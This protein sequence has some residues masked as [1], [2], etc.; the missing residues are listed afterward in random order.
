MPHQPRATPPNDRPLRVAVL[1][2]WHVHAPDYAREASEHA[3]TEVVAVWDADTAR[4]AEAAAALGVPHAEDLDE[5]LARD[6]LDAVTV[7][8]ETTRHHEVIS[9]A[10]R[11]GK[12][13]FTEKL[14]AP[15]VEES[16]DLV[17][18]ADAHGLALAVSL[19]RLTEPTTLAA[20]DAVRSGRL[21][22]L[23]YARFRMAHDGWLADWL[24]ERFADP[25]DAVGG[26]LTDLGC[27][28]SYLVQL[29][30]GARPATVAAAYTHHTGR[31][32]EDNAVVVATYP[33]GAIGV[34]EASFVT[35]PGAFAFELRG[36]AGSIVHG[37]GGER[38]LAKGPAFDPDAWTELPLPEPGPT[39]F[40]IWVAQVRN[41][42]PA[43]EGL[44]RAVD[45]TRFVV[46][47]NAAARTSAPT[48]TPTSTTATSTPTT[49]IT[50]GS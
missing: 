1:G 41:G 13:V 6:D 34:A 50:E 37:F 18:L 44:R 16:E 21:G 17:R 19:P 2:W 25:A 39:P 20:L 35:V 24:P 7:T 26:A 14:L 27:H 47:A 40:A 3:D 45:L 22:E 48:T 8:T 33:S 42:A 30:L 5:L 10:L 4:G 23:T 43:D 36:T 28:P 38:T 12:H 29:F 15:T 31:P 32:V 46:S 49:R 11:A 9:A